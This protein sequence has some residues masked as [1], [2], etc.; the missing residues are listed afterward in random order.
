MIL[1]ILLILK[2]VVDKKNKKSSRNLD[3]II[4]NDLN[5]NKKIKEKM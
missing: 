1:I 2:I 3:Y 5:E 4:K